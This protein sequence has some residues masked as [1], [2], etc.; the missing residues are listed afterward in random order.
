[1]ENKKPK[2]NSLSEWRKN[3]SSAYQAANEKGLIEEICKK[4]GWI[5]LKRGGE[6]G[7]KKDKETC[8]KEALKYSSKSE[9]FKNNSS[10]YHA[11][12]KLNCFQE[13]IRHMKSIRK[14][15][16]KLNN[17]SLET[18]IKSAKKYRICSEWCSKDNA[19]FKKAK[20]EGWL[21]M[22]TPHMKK[23]KIWNKNLL[24]ENIKQ[25][26]NYSDWLK[27]SRS[28]Y[29]FAR[30]KRLI[31]FVKKQMN[32]SLN[33]VYDK[34]QVQKIDKKTGKVIGCFESLT[35]GAKSV[36]K[37]RKNVGGISM[38]CKNNTTAYGFLWKIIL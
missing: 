25:Y 11:S 19:T 17:L 28:A 24:L 31:N 29:V 16:I 4:T 27:E 15:K 6:K 8:I 13:C 37:G 21:P 10:S 33:S 30:K 18:C 7:E 2:Y 20:K 23:Q 5:Y 22:C 14:E 38:A 9:W 32:Y 12:K 36:G 26:S 34:K 1:M 3:N 35:D